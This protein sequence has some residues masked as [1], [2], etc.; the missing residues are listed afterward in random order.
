M[1]EELTMK[2]NLEIIR[3]FYE[4]LNPELIDPD[5]DW[6][7]ADGFPVDGHYQGRKAVQEWAAE[8]AAQ[9]DIG[10]MCPNNC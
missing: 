6:N 10:R 2:T 9:F 8:L 7:V 4:T 5:V 3:E 1:L